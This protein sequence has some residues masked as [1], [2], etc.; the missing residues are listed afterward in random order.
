MGI[1]RLDHVNFVIHDPH[2]TLHFIVTLLDWCDWR[3]CS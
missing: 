3:G 1:K 2:A